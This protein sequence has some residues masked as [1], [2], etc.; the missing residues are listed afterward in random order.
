MTMHEHVESW[1][2]LQM[3]HPRCPQPNA[4]AEVSAQ[5]MAAL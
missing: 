4:I 3:A 1:Q 5:E 2:A